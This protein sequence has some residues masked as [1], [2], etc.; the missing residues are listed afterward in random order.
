MTSASRLERK[1]P[2]SVLPAAPLPAFP[3]SGSPLS[4]AVVTLGQSSLTKSC[5]LGS[6]KWPERQSEVRSLVSPISLT[7][8]LLPNLVSKIRRDR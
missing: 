8:P 7:I 6:D 4:E 3:A 2:Q 5:L 1:Q